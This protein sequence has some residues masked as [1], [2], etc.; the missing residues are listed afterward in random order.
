VERR[1]LHFETDAVR[2]LPQIPN[3]LYVNRS[4]MTWPPILS[5]RLRLIAPNIAEF[6]GPANKSSLAAFLL[7]SGYRFVGD[8]L[9]FARCQPKSYSGGFFGW[10]PRHAQNAPP[11]KVTTEKL[12]DQRAERAMIF[13]RRLFD[14]F[15]EIGINPKTD[16]R[17]L[18]TFL[19]HGLYSIYFI[20]M[21]CRNKPLQLIRPAETDHGDGSATAAPQLIHSLSRP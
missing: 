7:F 1:S 14:G 9:D 6:F 15:F 2:S 16:P 11:P 8:V 4:R 18:L 5:L 10:P 3:V 20:E 19:R 21:S 17:C 13:S 12:F